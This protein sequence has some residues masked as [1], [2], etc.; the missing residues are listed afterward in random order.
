MY[1]TFRE[2]GKKLKK[3]KQGEKE[4]SLPASWMPM[5]PRCDYK[6]FKLPPNHAEFRK[7][8]KL[9]SKTAKKDRIVAVER[10]QNPF[11]WEKYQRYCVAAKLGV[12]MVLN[13]SMQHSVMY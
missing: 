5:Q 9:F 8:Q 11:M 7:V 2:A 10:V 12:L 1:S 6:R 3:Q 13:A 4:N